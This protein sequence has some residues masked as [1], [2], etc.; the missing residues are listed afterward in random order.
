MARPLDR[1]A[2]LRPRAILLA[3][4]CRGAFM[5]DDAERIMSKLSER[6]RFFTLRWGGPLVLVLF[7]AFLASI[8]VP[9]FVGGGS[10]KTHAIIS[11]LQ[12]LDGAVQ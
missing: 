7:V 9:N 10:N 12:Q 11:N 3:K 6:R 5:G 1:N 2:A 4:A 8:A